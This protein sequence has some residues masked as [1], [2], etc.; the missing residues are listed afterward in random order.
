MRN[1]SI[2]KRLS[3]NYGSQANGSQASS[4]LAA[5]TSHNTKL[6]RS[7]LTGSATNSDS[8]LS[9]S[10]SG[11]SST[12]SLHLSAASEV[13][14]ELA[15]AAAAAAAVPR[16]P[17]RRR[18]AF[19]LADGVI[20]RLG[21]GF[22][23]QIPF[24]YGEEA[25]TVERHALLLALGGRR[26]AGVGAAL[27]V[28]VEHQAVHADAVLGQVQRLDVVQVGNVLK[29]ERSFRQRSGTRP[30]VGV[31]R[32]RRRIGVLLDRFALDGSSRRLGAEQRLVAP[33]VALAARRSVLRGVAYDVLHQTVE[34]QFL[35]EHK[36]RAEP[37]SITS[38]IIR[39]R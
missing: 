20:G 39:H 35:L 24:D 13:D 22:Q 38:A 12:G 17:Q 34:G 26:Q 23:T 11:V 8:M 7:P 15:P 5:P 28:G 19:A 25:V 31:E 2:H 36:T 30:A 4:S 33:L 10:S 1:N 14:D 37:Q 9:F 16:T 32:V 29:A 6:H 18:A 3:W 21:S 27:D